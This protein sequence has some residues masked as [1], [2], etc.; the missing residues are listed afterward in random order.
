MGFG[1]RRAGRKKIVVHG[2][3]HVDDAAGRNPP[4]LVIIPVRLAD[5]EK[6]VAPGKNKIKEPPLQPAPYA[7]TVRH[8]AIVV[9][10]S[11][12]DRLALIVRIS[13]RANHSCTLPAMKPDG[14]GFPYFLLPV[15]FFPGDAFVPRP[16]RH[17]PT[18]VAPKSRVEIS[19]LRIAQKNNAK[20]ESRL[21]R[22][23]PEQR[24]VILDRMTDEVQKAHG[25]RLSPHVARQ[26]VSSFS[27]NTAGAYSVSATVRA[28]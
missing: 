28:P 5:S 18:H 19:T 27:R 20:I 12:Q 8:G 23:P 22:N 17:V 6:N 24:G 10:A 1:R 7:R 11:H 25:H 4:A 9:L 13:D 15:G 21:G 14:V 16:Q 3:A 26:A 2:I